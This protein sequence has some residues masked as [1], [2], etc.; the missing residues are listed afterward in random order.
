MHWYFSFLLLGI[1]TLFYPQSLS[2]D[3]NSKSYKINIGDS[4]QANVKSSVKNIALPA[5]FK[6]TEA[7]QNSFAAWL[8]NVQL[9]TNKTVY[10]Y[11][12]LPKKNQST[13]FAVLDIPVGNKDLQQCA[14]AVMRLRASYLFDQKRMSE[15]VFYDNSRNAYPYSGSADPGHFNR[16]LESVFAYCGTASLEKQLHKKNIK[17]IQPGDVFIKGGFPGHAV[18]V[19]DIAADG[20]GEKIYMLAQSY[21]PAQDIHILNNLQNSNYSPWYLLDEEQIFT[22]E[23]IF[24]PSQ[25]YTW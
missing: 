3:D 20:K 23:W 19:M 11:N 21:M 15:I 18:I 22:P 14:D 1:S 4:I 5:G 13:Q 2:H 12:G 9:K 6:R 24:N 7:A 17:D 8:R 10:L 25:L 16:Y